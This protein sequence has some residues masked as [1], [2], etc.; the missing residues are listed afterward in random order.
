[1]IGE[2]YWYPDFQK[3]EIVK[4]EVLDTL[5]VIPDAVKIREIESQ[6]EYFVTQSYLFKDKRRAKN[7]MIANFEETIRT[8]TRHLVNAQNS[9]DKIKGVFA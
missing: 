6:I 8:Y 2:K 5:T 7:L 1:M 9:L 4:V 3:L